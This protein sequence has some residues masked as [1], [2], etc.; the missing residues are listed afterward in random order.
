MLFLFVPTSQAAGRSFDQGRICRNKHLLDIDEEAIPQRYRVILRS[1]QHA[2]VEPEVAAAM[3]LEDE[4]LEELQALEREVEKERAAKEK[5]RAAKEQAEEMM[6]KE[7]TEKE[8]LLA[9]IKQAG[10]EH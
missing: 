10:L 8:R 4:V 3:D 7:R 6:T 9:I 5:E 2:V 1:L